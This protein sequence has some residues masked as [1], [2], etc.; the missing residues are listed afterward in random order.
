[1]NN[2]KGC[3][4]LSKAGHDK[5]NIYVVLNESNGYVF[6]SDGKYKLIDNPKKKKIRHIELLGKTDKDL[7][8]KINNNIEVKNEEI[9]RSIKCYKRDIYN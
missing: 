3:F 8:E 5:G 9:K 6:L 7:S 2:I 1:M 4:V